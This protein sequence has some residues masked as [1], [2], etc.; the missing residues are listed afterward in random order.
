MNDADPHGLDLR[1]SVNLVMS[2]GLLMINKIIISDHDGI[3]R[4]R[5]LPSCIIL[6][7][8]FFG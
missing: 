4:S 7:I 6:R 5:S 8:L 2:N 1:F 3:F